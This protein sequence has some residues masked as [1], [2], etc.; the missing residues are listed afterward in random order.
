MIEYNANRC[1]FLLADLLV[2]PYI[3]HIA[4]QLQIYVLRRKTLMLQQ[5]GYFYLPVTIFH[6]A[7]YIPEIGSQL[8][9][10]MFARIIIQRIEMHPVYD[11]SGQRA[12]KKVQ[13]ILP[14][15]EQAF[16]E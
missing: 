8:V 2:L 11:L 4:R 16:K 13:E 1:E 3:K 14:H 10:Y 7:A 6:V 5:Q 15:R 12:L 9:V